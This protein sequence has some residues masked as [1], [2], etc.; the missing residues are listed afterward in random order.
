V[1]GERELDRGGEDAQR[2]APCVLDEDGLAQPEV[3]RHRLPPSLWDFGAVEEDAER[4]PTRPVLGAEHP[5]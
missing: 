1:T 4:V 2:A 3:G 5:Q